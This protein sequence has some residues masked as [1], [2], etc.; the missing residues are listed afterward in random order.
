MEEIISYPTAKLADDLGIRE[1]TIMAYH[2]GKPTLSHVYSLDPMIKE[3][4]YAPLQSELQSYIRKTYAVHIEIYCNASGWGWIL[5][6][7]NGT[8]IKEIEDD[9][10]FDT[11]EVALEIGLQQALKLVQS[12]WKSSSF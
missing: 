8:T 3:E 6:K 1:Y 11:Y 12:G 10:F 4:L 9:I 2:D 5:T 7:L